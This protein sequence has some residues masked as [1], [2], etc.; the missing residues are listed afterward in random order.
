MQLQLKLHRHANLSH[1]PGT[2]A[3]RC[4]RLTSCNLHARPPTKEDYCRLHYQ[5]LSVTKHQDLTQDISQYLFAQVKVGAREQSLEGRDGAGFQSHRLRVLRGRDVGQGTQGL[6][7]RFRMIYIKQPTTGKGTWSTADVG[8][9]RRRSRRM[10]RYMSGISW[11]T[12]DATNPCGERAGTEGDQIECG[13][14]RAT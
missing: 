7:T 14:M 2:T 13:R 9:Q 6:V 11:C 4:L 8:T 3:Y 12:P 5:L 10:Q 1:V